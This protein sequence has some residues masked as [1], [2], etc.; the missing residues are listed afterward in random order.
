[1]KRRTGR[2]VTLMVVIALLVMPASVFPQ[3]KN[4][5]NAVG[6]VQFELVGQFVNMT[7]TT[8]QQFGYLTYINGI[9]GEESVFNPGPQNETTALFTFYNDTVTERVIN[10]GP[11][12]IINRV[13]T[14]TVYLDTAPDGDFSNPDSFRDGVPIQTSVLRQQVVFNPTTGELTATL[15]NAITSSDFFHLGNH[16]FIFGK[17]GQKFR[18]TFFG[19]LVTLPGHVA[20][21]AVGPYLTRP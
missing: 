10:N 17:V 4:S 15:V 21:F 6:D 3:G 13:G 20:G 11:F 7:P 18:M 2:I 16:N 9:S 8:S 19:H 14:T 1:M 12:R 5:N